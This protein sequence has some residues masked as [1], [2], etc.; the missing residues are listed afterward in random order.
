[1]PDASIEIVHNTAAHRFEAH[2]DGGLA[3]CDYRRIGNVLQ[4]H[5]TE[6]PVA[7][8]GRGIAGQLVRATLDYAKEN[9]LRVAPYCSYVRSWMRRHPEYQPLLAAGQS[10]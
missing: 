8:E 10:V 9:G 2:V 4:V 5:H 1:M 6:V 7:L 3:R